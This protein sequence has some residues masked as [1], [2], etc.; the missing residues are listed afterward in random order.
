MIVNDEQ[1]FDLAENYADW[2]DF[3]RWTFRDSDKLVGFVLAIQQAEREACAK[4][5]DD[6]GAKDTLTNYFLVAARKIRERG[7]K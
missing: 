7:E 5:C 6:L 1:I 2:D 3:G 4:I